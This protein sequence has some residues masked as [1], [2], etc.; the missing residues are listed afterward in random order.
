MAK[1]E[2][3]TLLKDL[4]RS[5]QRHL[6]R[7]RSGAPRPLRDLD[8]RAIVSGPRLYLGSDQISPRLSGTAGR[9]EYS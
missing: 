6:F 4:H 3:S 5:R 1:D 9:E 7:G 8:V 2:L